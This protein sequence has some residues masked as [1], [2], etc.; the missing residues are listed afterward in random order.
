MPVSGEM[1]PVEHEVVID[2]SSDTSSATEAAPERAADG[3]VAAHQRSV[4]VRGG[5]ARDL[6]PYLLSRICISTH[7]HRLPRR[8]R[9]QFSSCYRR[10]TRYT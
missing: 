6:A 1:P 8:R 3:A 2:G 5:R 4:A 7:R 9:P 10:S